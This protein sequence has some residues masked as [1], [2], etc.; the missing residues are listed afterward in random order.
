M[1]GFYIN[2][3]K[4]NLKSTL[5]KSV[6]NICEL[7]YQ[8]QVFKRKIRRI[9]LK[10]IIHGKGCGREF[11]IGETENAFPVVRQDFVYAILVSSFK[12]LVSLPNATVE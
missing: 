10:I 12:V 7:R 11:K 8:A 4:K 9:G 1:L 2:P 6:K 3:N 5:N